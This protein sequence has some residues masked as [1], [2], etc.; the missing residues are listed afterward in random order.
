MI[1]EPAL[2]VRNTQTGTAPWW[3]RWIIPAAVIV[4]VFF[5][6]EPALEADFVNWDDNYVIQQNDAYRGFTRQHLRWMFTATQFGHYQ[7][8]TWLSYALD[9]YLWRCGFWP[10]EPFAYHLTNVLLHAAS[11]V[12]FYFVARRLLACALAGVEARRKKA[13]VLGGALA[14]LLFALHPLRVESVAWVTERRDVLAMLFYLMCVAAYL[15]Y[16]SAC[17]CLSEYARRQA[18]HTDSSGTGDSPVK[19]RHRRVAYATALVCFAL[20]LLAKAAAVTLPL[21]LLIL[22]AYPLRRVIKPSVEAS[23][24]Q[25]RGWIAVLADKVPFLVLSLAA[26]LQAVRAQ[27]CADAFYS[28]AEY[29]LPARVGQASYG[30][31]FYVYKTLL[32]FNLGPLYQMPPRDVLVGPQFWISAALVAAASVAVFRLRHARPGW[33]VAWGVYVVTLA[34]ML[35]FVQSGPQLVADRYSYFSCLPWAVMGGALLTIIIGRGGKRAGRA[36]SAGSN[37]RFGQPLTAL[38]VVALLVCLSKATFL[39]AG[40]WGH[41]LSLWAQGVR[42]CPN[43]SIAHVNYADALSNIAHGKP[44]HDALR[45]T[46]NHYRWA[47]E[48]DPSDVIAW[49][50]LGKVL[51]IL[52]DV[53]EAIEAYRRA[54]ELSPLRPGLHLEFA[55]LLTR[56]GRW[57]DGVEV[58]RQGVK[59]H[60]DDVALAHYLAD[61]LATHP[62]GSIGVLGNEP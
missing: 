20:S 2:P 62:D 23:V 28:L 53:D 13:F 16:A 52:G 38:G 17:A 14:T 48:L 15:R 50:H 58:L 10:L 18:E 3:V 1:G 41:P 26:A 57:A 44:Y 6:F 49:A 56:D 40:V 60:P 12:V 47:L 34:P 24:A 33:L 46:T 55:R 43:S 36:G 4:A 54:I 61:L 31:V 11:A 7:P 37:R 19:T 25:R 32:P 30:L 39:Q 21:A 35:G 8:L 5:T 29:D 27:R 22:D 59:H 45:K 42:A 9:D 51:G